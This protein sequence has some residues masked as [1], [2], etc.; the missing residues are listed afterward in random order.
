MI[1]HCLGSTSTS[2]NRTCVILVSINLT[3]M[4]PVIPNAILCTTSIPTTTE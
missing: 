4:K 2:T 1:H 3:L